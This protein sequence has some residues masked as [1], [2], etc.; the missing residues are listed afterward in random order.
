MN[1]LQIREKIS[2]KH[3]EAQAIVA[4]AEE[5]SRE[6]TEQDQ[7]QFDALLAEIG[8]DKG[9]QSTGLY[10]NLYR[11]ERLEALQLAMALSLIHI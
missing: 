9:E 2:E 1:P 4:L 8:E 3:S 6:L 11:S 7:T 5:E 10:K